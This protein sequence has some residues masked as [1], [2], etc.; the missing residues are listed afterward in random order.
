MPTILVVDDLASD[1]RL[2]GGLLMTDED[3]NVEFAVNGR[4]ALERIAKARPDLVVTDL[5]MP[6]MDGL[7]LVGNIAY[8][9]R[10]LPVILMTSQGSE[11]IAVKALQQGAASY[12]PKRLLDRY[13]VS[14]VQRL[15]ATVVDQNSRHRLMGCMIENECRFQLES[16][17]KL[18]RA[19]LGYLQESLS[20]M[21]LLDEMEL[22]RVGVALEEALV[23]ALYH[24]NLEIGSELRGE[25]D[26]AYRALVD[27]RLQETPY[28][29]R[30]IHLHVK[31]SAFQ[32]TFVIR[33]EGPGFDTSKLP[34]PTDPRNV[35]KASG[36]GV[37]LIRTFMDEMMYNEAGNQLTMVKRT[38]LAKSGE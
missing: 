22:L 11:E 37:L 21:G 4:E 32:T 35:E 2:V 6:E 14:T 3:L 23:N 27:Q 12:V 9:Y 29:E 15:L 19:C 24:G 33:D 20:H 31:L 10:G 17:P 36:R 8:K 13:L 1:R 5:M 16:D 38:K 34:D 18:V 26:D 30:H 7:E 28:C 25:D